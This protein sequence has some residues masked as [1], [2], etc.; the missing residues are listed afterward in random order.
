V[1]I[2]SSALLIFEVA[3][4]VCQTIMKCQLQ[5]VLGQVCDVGDW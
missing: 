1:F 5:Y 3:A 2:G 4:P